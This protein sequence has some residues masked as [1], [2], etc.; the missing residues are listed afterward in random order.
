MDRGI[1]VVLHYS[2]RDDDGILEVVTVPWHERDE[3]VAADGQLAVLGVRAVGEDLS[4][5][6][7]LARLDDGLLV[8]AGAGVGTHELAQRVGKNA[9]G[10]V[11]FDDLRLAEE[12]LLGNGELAIGGGDDD[13]G[14]GGGDDAVG[15]GNDHGT[16]VAGGLGLE[17]GADE[18]CLGN[19]KRHTLALHVRSHQRSVGV[20]VL[21]ERDEACGDGNKLL[22]RDVHVVNGIRGGLDEL[23]A[24]T[25]VDAVFLETA[26]LV[27]HVGCLG[28]EV[29]FLLVGC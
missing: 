28:D 20:I 21:K 14:G 7:L 3:D 29:V 15:L 12:F 22:R 25:G 4:F 18:R 1:D 13:L 27:D 11:C 24:L 26:C 17:T 5:L 8:D 10:H 16:G 6:D 23:T 9:L 2:L 19:E